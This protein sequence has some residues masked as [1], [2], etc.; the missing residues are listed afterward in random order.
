[1]SEVYE[2]LEQTMHDWH[3]LEPEERLE[4]FSAL[5]LERAEELLDCMNAIDQAELLE[6]MPEAERRVWMRYLDP[7]DLA[8]VLCEVSDESRE[9]MLALL[10]ERNRHEVVA[11]LAYAEDDAGGLMNP[12]FARMRPD[13][14]IEE[15]IR[16]LRKQSQSRIPLEH[17]YVLDEE[18]YLLGEVALDSLFS[19]RPD[20]LVRDIVD[21][22]VV[23]APEDMDQEEVGALFARYGLTAMPVVDAQG[24]MKGL[25]T[26]DDVVDVIYEENTE[27]AQ[28]FG[29]MEALDDPYLRTGFWELVRKRAGWL[30]LLLLG[31]MLT[32]SAMAKYEL[33]INSV[34]F[35]A[36]FVP[37]IISSGGNSGSQA[38]TL[39]VRAMAMGEVNPRDWPLVLWREL[40]TGAVMGSILGLVGVARILIWQ[41]LFDGIYGEHYLEIAGTVGL[42]LLSVVILGCL[43]GSMLPFLLR[44]LKF[45][46]ASA[47]AP[48]VA[49]L[50]DVSGLVVYF[51]IA[52]V[53]LAKAISM[54]VS[55]SV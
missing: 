5:P 24:R 51:S 23:T 45:D 32:A 19:A 21:S 25:I 30:V 33:Q 47:S 35:L 12:R 16:Y 11:L 14:T 38:S 54:G 39:V 42:S 9:Q 37:L 36:V 52:S 27:D 8:D 49:T 18:Q 50:V 29:G 10:D 31:E 34:W 4:A 17:L 26:A 53:L 13:L 55:S 1:M 7:D 43:A 3:R 44:C 46:P 6:I 20:E 48:F 40:R 2:Q 41:F 22:D 28:K 15:A